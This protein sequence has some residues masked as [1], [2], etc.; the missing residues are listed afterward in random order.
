[1]NT[2]AS[3]LYVYCI[4]KEPPR[5][6]NL[7]DLV[8]S[9]D[10]LQFGN[11]YVTISYVDKDDFTQEILKKNLQNLE[12]V[13]KYVIIHEKVIETVMKDTPVIPSQFATV[14][15]DKKN[16]EG[17]MEKHAG[18]LEEKL[19]YLEGKEEWGVKI[20]CDV[21][22]LR[23]VSNVSDRILLLEQEITLSSVGKAYLL[24]KKKTKI[25]QELV[26]ET[27]STYRTLF[28]D[29][30][31]GHSFDTKINELSKES[32][33]ER[34]DEMIL[35]AAF[36][37]GQSDVGNFITEVEILKK[38]YNSKGFNFECVGPWPPYNFSSL[39]QR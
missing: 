23:N 38:D 22:I 26:D 27:I 10:F 35:N 34:N 21:E 24:K 17:F 4:T 36:L 16:L 32:L 18:H 12:W 30:L 7:T 19:I 31:A 8:D 9:I 39:S 5:L 15:I 6:T 33:K 20:Y 25:L 1:M 29:N 2:D 14:F 11:L 13:S 3:Y 37:V 28:R